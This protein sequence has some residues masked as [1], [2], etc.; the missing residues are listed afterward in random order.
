MPTQHAHH[1]ARSASGTTPPK[2]PPQRLIAAEGLFFPAAAAYG[3]L[4]VPASV[5]AM[6]T[7]RHWLSAFSGVTNHAHEL[8]FG[9]GLAVVTGFLVTRASRARIAV[10]FGLWLLG[11]LS[12]LL[13]PG[14]LPALLFTAGFAGMLAATVVPPFLR[15]AKKLRNRAVAPLLIALCLAPPAL[16]IALTQGPT[17]LQFLL[18]QQSVL[19]FALLMLF[20]GGRIIAPAAAGAIT[21]AGGELLHRVQPPIEGALLLLL[22]LAV[23]LLAIPG[24]RVLTGLL[25]LTAAALALLRLL[26]WRLWA[27]RSRPDLW[28]LGIG[29]GWLVIGLALFGLSS[30]FQLLPASHAT[31]AITVGAL[32]TLSTAVM[33]RV[34][35][36]RNKRDPADVRLLPWIAGLMSA[37]AATRLIGATSVAALTAAA[38]LWSIALLLLLALLLRVPA[39]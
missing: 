32:G 23:A 28:C 36:T 31:H 25:L 33:A 6:L 9:F 18:L 13:A 1:P 3:A 27:C 20:M 38:A 35:L 39:R 21:R 26:R 7:G 17:W 10:L 11:R 4:A 24:G 16:Q 29:Y 22:M 5:H 37:A 2:S 15:G 34:R 30:A 8:L 19:L 12:F 14:S